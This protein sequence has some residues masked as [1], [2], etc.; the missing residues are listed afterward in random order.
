MAKNGVS[1]WGYKYAE[2]TGIQRVT[3]RQS[4]DS[5]YYDLRGMKVTNPQKGI[6]IKNGK[7]IV[8]K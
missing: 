7:K 5:D 3:S 4:D 6:Y 2:A 8:V 1:I